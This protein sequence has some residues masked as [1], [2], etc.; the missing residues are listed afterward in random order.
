MELSN[1]FYVLAAVLFI[2][3]L[4]KLSHPKSARTGNAM[5]AIGMLI[6]IITTLV[7]YGGIDYK[8]IALGVIVG[9]IIG[10]TFAIKVEMTGM[11][12]MVALFN[13]FGGGASALV[14]AAEFYTKAA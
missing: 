6:A 10:G 4:K 12:Q 14:A 1:L 5:A 9:S 13:G 11:P 3:G 2:L 7:A 8:L